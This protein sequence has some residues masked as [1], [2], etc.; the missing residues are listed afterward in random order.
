[1][2]TRA[3]ANHRGGVPHAVPWPREQAREH[4]GDHRQAGGRFVAAM[5]PRAYLL[6][7]PER[8]IRSALGFSAGLLR[9]IGEVAVPRTVRGGQLYKSLVDTTLRYVIEQVG[10]AKGVY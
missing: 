4:D 6:S 5:L 10:N 9:E 3:S 1:M 8:A 7:I 2:A